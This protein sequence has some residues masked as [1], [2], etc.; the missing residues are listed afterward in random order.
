MEV[1]IKYGKIEVLYRYELL[2]K[3]LIKYINTKLPNQRQWLLE[4]GDQV[5]TIYM[6]FSLFLSAPL[7][8]SMNM[9][10]GRLQYVILHD[11]DNQ[12]AFNFLIRHSVFVGLYRWLSARQ[13][14]LHC[15]R[16]G[17][18]AVLH[19]VGNMMPQTIT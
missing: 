5:Q 16:T 7:K 18:I 9:P 19:Q 11:G 4:I 12:Y 15:W 6:K 2:N 13:Q 3:Q 1:L 10:C 17:V 14:K 8:F